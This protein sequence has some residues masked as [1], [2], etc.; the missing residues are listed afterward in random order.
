M[1]GGVGKRVK[2]GVVG[3]RGAVGQ[4]L[5]RVLE[6]HPHVDIDFG[7]ADR[8]APAEV[9]GRSLDVLFLSAPNGVAPS[10][11][12]AIDAA[13]RDVVVIDI[14][15][16]FRSDPRWVYGL[17][18]RRRDPIRGARRI[19]NPGCYA[20]G[21]QLGIDP[22]LD[23]LGGA[24]TV[25]GV[26]GYSGAGTKPSPK[27]DVQRLTDNLLPYSLVDHAHER[28]VSAQLGRPVAF[29]PHVASFF[30]G[31]TLTISL[32]L[33]AP[34]P[35]EELRARLRSRYQ[36][37]RLVQVVDD[38]PEVKDA[39]GRPGVTIGGLC[40]DEAGTRAALVVTLDNLLK[41]A[42]TQA[43]QNMNL[44]CGFEELSGIEE[45]T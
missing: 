29:L 17:P 18:E 30:A 37:E 5:M 1:G 15:S 28:E 19:A 44:A 4:L 43:V 3:G 9:A 41:G 10:Y 40:V 23:V 38:I 2:V 33:A 20:T 36:G 25:F 24:P 12:E 42:A 31:I 34:R 8:K 14:S 45:R 32:P 27:N 35:L 6:A 21:A 26:S 11:V 22:F 7:D 16:D 13:G 39:R